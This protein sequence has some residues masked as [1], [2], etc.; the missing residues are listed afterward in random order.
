MLLTGVISPN[1]TVDKIVEAQ[2]HPAI[3]CWIS[4]VISSAGV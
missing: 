1:P 3:Y 4:E 2:Y